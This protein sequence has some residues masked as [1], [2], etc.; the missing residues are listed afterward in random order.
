MPQQFST[1]RKIFDKK[2]YEAQDFYEDPYV[3]VIN[4]D[5]YTGKT[6]SER[7]KT[8]TDRSNLVIYP[9]DIEIIFGLSPRAALRLLYDIREAAG[10]GKWAVVSPGTL[11]RITGLVKET[12]DDFIRES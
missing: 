5:L 9:K 10:L 3:Y 7:K 1:L 6:V 4:N 11:C 12:V 8:D 2:A